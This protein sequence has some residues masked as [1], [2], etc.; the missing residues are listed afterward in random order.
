M[1]LLVWIKQAGFDLNISFQ[2][3]ANGTE[4]MRRQAVAMPNIFDNPSK[5]LPIC[6]SYW[7]FL[8]NPLLVQ[9]FSSKWYIHS[10]LYYKC[11]IKTIYE[12]ETLHSYF[13]S[14]NCP[15]SRFKIW[16]NKILSQN[17][18]LNK[19]IGMIY[20]FHFFFPVKVRRFKWP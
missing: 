3:W 5:H 16:F 17:I 12:L 7:M 9:M 19:H 4:S 13:V 6:F 14:A 18:K 2:D 15:L 8:K 1:R 20:S 11:R 10:Y